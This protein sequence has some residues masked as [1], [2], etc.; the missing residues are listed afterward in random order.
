MKYFTKVKEIGEPIEANALLGT[1]STTVRAWSE[2]R[3]TS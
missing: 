1:P 2:T 3:R